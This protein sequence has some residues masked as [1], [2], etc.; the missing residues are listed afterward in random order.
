MVAV[1]VVVAFAWSPVRSRRRR[2]LCRRRQHSLSI[3]DADCHS[4]TATPVPPSP[5]PTV[6]PSP[7]ATPVPP[8]ATATPTPVPPTVTPTLVPRR[9]RSRQRLSHRR[10]QW[11]PD[12]T[13][14]PP[15]PTPVP[16]AEV[17]TVAPIR[18]FGC[19]SATYNEVQP[20]VGCAMWQKEKAMK[21]VAQRF[22]RA[23]SCGWVVLSFQAMRSLPGSSMPMTAPTPRLPGMRMSQTA[24]PQPSPGK[25]FEPTGALA[26]VWK[27]AAGAKNR[28]G[29][30]VEPEK[31]GTGA[32]SSSTA[33]GCSGSLQAGHA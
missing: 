28:L 11:R 27:E 33:A 24:K 4:P 9:R 3:T 15:P 19:V 1:L 29:L 16:T 8:A 13:Q 14:V 18:G 12:A 17:C 25:P 5:T 20:F 22:E 26:R 23:T 32:C 6:A 21:F 10:Q 31:G 30:A 7:T 2:R